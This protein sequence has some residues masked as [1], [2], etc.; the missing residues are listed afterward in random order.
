M[1]RASLA[2]GVAALR[3][4]TFVAFD[5]ALRR[6]ALGGDRQASV[7]RLRAPAL[8]AGF[9]EGAVA[10]FAALDGI[11]AA[12]TPTMRDALRTWQRQQREAFVAARALLGSLDRQDTTTPATP[13]GDDAVVQALVAQW[14]L[15]LCPDLLRFGEDQSDVLASLR[16]VAR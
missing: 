7:A 14:R 9:S 13:V 5:E 2:S 15:Q 8:R 12:P 16:D 11:D 6:L 10:L 4:E 3:V 1:A